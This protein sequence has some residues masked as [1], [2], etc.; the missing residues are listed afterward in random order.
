MKLDDET[1]RRLRDMFRGA[2]CC[3]CGAPATRLARNRFYCDRHF[4][5]RQAGGRDRQY[6]HP[7]L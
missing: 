4:P 5:Y 7:K 3:R 1:E 2:V 6:R